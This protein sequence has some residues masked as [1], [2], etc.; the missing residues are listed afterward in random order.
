M[1]QALSNPRQERGLALVQG[2]RARFRPIAGDSYFVPSQTSAGA[3]YVVDAVAG[4][5]SCP[6]FEERKEP[7]KHVFA[8]RYLRH[9][10]AM[11]DGTSVVTESIRQDA[12]SRLGRWHRGARAQA[13]PAV[14][15]AS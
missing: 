9:E 7:C 5:C 4:Q 2:K 11:P 3:G 15:T 8:I 13:R 6:D 10:L 12:A 14:R 1:D